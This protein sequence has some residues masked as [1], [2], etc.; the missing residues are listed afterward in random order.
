MCIRFYLYDMPY[1]PV[2]IPMVSP[3]VDKRKVH[4]RHVNM[5]DAKSVHP[6]CGC[7]H[8][9]GFF[10]DRGY[11]GEDIACRKRMVRELSVLLVVTWALVAVVEQLMLK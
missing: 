2:V 11:L 10:G 9:D 8:D 1:S 5:Q 6:F 7:S 4:K 3:H